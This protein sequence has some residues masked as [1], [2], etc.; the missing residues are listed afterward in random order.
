VSSDSQKDRVFTAPR[1]I[2]FL[3]TGGILLTLLV[4]TPVDEERAIALTTASV[5][6]SDILPP[7]GDAYRTENDLSIETHITARLD[8]DAPERVRSELKN[9]AERSGF[10]LVDEGRDLPVL[11]LT[12]VSQPN[13]VVL[14]ATLTDVPEPAEG[15]KRI[16]D[17]RSVVPPL[18]AIL[19]A[20]FFRQLIVALL[21]AVM[22][23]A[24]LHF[25]GNPISDLW[26]GVDHY[27]WGNVTSE[28]NMQILA[29]TF[30]LVGMVIVTTRAG[31]SQGLI[32]VVSKLASSARSTRVA[33]WLM[34][35]IVFFDDYANAIVVGTTVRPMAD[36]QRVSREKLSYLVDS[37][38]APVAGLAIISTWIAFELGLLQPLIDQLGLQLEPGV[39]T[40]AY[41]FF[42]TML[43]VRF[44][45]LTTIVF[46]FVGAAS[47]RDYGP[48]LRAERRA[49]EKGQVIAPNARPL[50]SRS[51]DDI[52]AKPGIPCRWYNAA[53]PVLVVVFSV[54]V[55]MLLSGRAA[56]EEAGVAFS[57]ASFETWKIAFGEADSGFVLLISSMIGSVVAIA[58]AVGQRLLTLPESIA[59]WFR[60][61]R[62]M[63]LAIAILVCAWAIQSVCRDLGT[64]VF[65]VSAVG[66]A[67]PPLAF[68][69]F[70]F[71]LAAGVAFATGTSWG[72]MG[73]LLPVILPWVYALTE[74]AGADMTI[75]MLSAAAVLDG[76]IMGDHC[77]PISDTTVL[78]S[79]ATS[80]DHID[81]VKTQLPYAL[82]C[83]LLAALAYLAMAAGA[84]SWVVYIAAVGGI[85]AIFYVVGKPIEQT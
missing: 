22:L 11:H 53:V 84:P 78:S 16:G 49:A 85:V 76:A 56:V 50:T 10:E 6:T 62:A 72:T 67:I 18:F 31:G 4:L 33:T 81:H 29:F 58:M 8:F 47:S 73:I 39:P 45:C 20:L 3:V 69:V 12:S 66:E 55:G 38:A 42:L 75:V 15:Q 24:L 35:L 27:I 48:M 79:I 5:A 71:F 37:T 36:R 83:T 64:N 9:A 14:S 25:T 82:T 17:W 46:V 52:A 34:G 44:Y 74:T 41:A 61:V 77:S 26:N 60:G 19:V 2:G 65:V 57:P 7:L 30:G 32:D 43:P 13:H 21:G 51:M 70:T 40:N 68:P 54:L 59:T 1:I 23:G 63:G 80:C 28:F